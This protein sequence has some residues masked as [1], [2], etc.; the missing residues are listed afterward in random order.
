M[1]EV[2]KKAAKSEQA[3][4]RD[5]HLPVHP[6]KPGSGCFDDLGKIGNGPAYPLPLH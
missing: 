5:Q 3:V 2:K 1:G 6:E 4:K